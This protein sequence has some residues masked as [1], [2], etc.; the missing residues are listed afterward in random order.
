MNP[1]ILNSNHNNNINNVGL[2]WHHSQHLPLPIVKRICVKWPCLSWNEPLQNFVGLRLE[3]YLS[4]GQETLLARVRHGIRQ[5]V[6]APTS[7]MSL[8]LYSWIYHSL[9][10]H[11]LSSLAHRSDNFLIF[12]QRHQDSR[13]KRMLASFDWRTKISL[14]GVR[15]D[16]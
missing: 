5:Q 16:V 3:W 8:A 1:V 14:P 10:S 11:W 7:H 6:M 4:H 15:V 13:Q 12:Q 9:T 2:Q